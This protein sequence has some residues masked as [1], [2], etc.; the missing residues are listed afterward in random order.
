MTMGDAKHT[1]VDYQEQETADSDQLQN[2]LDESQ[3]L[4]HVT[5]NFE[6]EPSIIHKVQ[7]MS[8]FMLEHKKILHLLQ[9]SGL[10]IKSLLKFIHK[11]EEIQQK[12]LEMLRHQFLHIPHTTKSDPS[13]LPLESSIPLNPM[14]KKN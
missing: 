1:Q 14:K 4:L 8:A 10:N 13:T 5:E 9:T 7:H 2:L 11:E 12:E 3:A 6:N